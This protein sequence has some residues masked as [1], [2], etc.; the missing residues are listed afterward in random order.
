[1]NAVVF[2]FVADNLFVKITLPD[3]RPAR[4]A[5]GVDGMRHGG[6]VPTNDGTDRPAFWSIWP[7]RTGDA[8]RRPYYIL[9]H[10]NILLHPIIL[11]RPNII[12]RDPND[13][14]HVV[15][16]DHEFI[17]IQFNIGALCR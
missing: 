3:L 17:L 15:W 4:F 1:M 8:M 12:T 11:C 7:I 6:F 13:P 10:L 5:G 2:L 9:R 16:H 14:V